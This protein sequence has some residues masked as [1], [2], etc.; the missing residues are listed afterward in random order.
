MSPA[1][2][3]AGS[4]AGPLLEDATMGMRGWIGSWP[5]YR[6]LAGKDKLGLGAAVKSRKTGELRPRVAVADKVV[7]SVCP[8]CAVGCGQNVYVRDGQVTQI[9]GDPDSPALPEGL[10]E[11]AADDR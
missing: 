6:Q 8:Y 5:A 3:T 11:P 4:T 10:G 1:R 7:R 9:E 2:G